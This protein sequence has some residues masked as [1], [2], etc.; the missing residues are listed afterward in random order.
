MV[1]DGPGR[2]V[3]GQS[4]EGRGLN[5]RASGEAVGPGEDKLWATFSWCPF[6]SKAMLA[7]EV[8]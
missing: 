2:A 6:Y 5:S 8:V 7:V 1:Q 3:G 4:R